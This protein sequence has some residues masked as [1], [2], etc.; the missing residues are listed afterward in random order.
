MCEQKKAGRSQTPNYVKMFCRMCSVRIQVTRPASRTSN[1]W[2][3]Q[4]KFPSPRDPVWGYFVFPGK[5]NM[6]F[7]RP[8]N[9]R[10][11]LCLNTKRRVFQCCPLRNRPTKTAPDRDSRAVQTE[12]LPEPTQQLCSCS[13][14]DYGGCPDCN[15]ASIGI[16]KNNCM[17]ARMQTN[18][19]R[20]LLIRGPGWKVP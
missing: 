11:Y 13:S 18:L 1:C 20:V 8:A 14:A 9:L 6:S 16:V 10:S 7:T 12:W 2:A 15:R 19:R 4:P 17:H 5:V 3:E